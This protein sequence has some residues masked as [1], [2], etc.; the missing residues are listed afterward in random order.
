MT[1]QLR[2]TWLNSQKLDL[3]ASSEDPKDG[4]SATCI[5]PA[6]GKLYVSY[7]TYGD[8]AVGGNIEV[9]SLSGNKLTLED[10]KAAANCDYNHLIVDGSKLYLAGSNQAGHFPPLLP[11]QDG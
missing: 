9:A 3:I 5:Q 11:L 1:R 10:S 4:E 8:K 2:T 7:H 6:N